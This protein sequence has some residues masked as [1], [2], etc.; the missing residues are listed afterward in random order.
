MLRDTLSVCKEVFTAIVPIALLTLCTLILIP[1][2]TPD[3][4]FRFISGTVMVI[5]GITLFLMGVKIG[6]LPMGETIGSAL[7]RIGTIP[8]IIL[9]TFS[10]GFFAAIAEPGVRVLATMILEISTSSI[11]KTAL[12]IAIATGIGFFVT[13]AILRILYAVPLPYL[14]TAGYGLALILALFSPPD[15]VPLAFDA[16]GVATGPI[17]APFI[18]S[19]GVGLTSVLGGR[20]SLS[21]G[22]GLIGLAAVGPVLGILIMGFFSS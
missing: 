2:T 9:I 3:A 15:F 21:D 10:F 17:T 14:L 7:P 6:V 19:L 13:T 4:Y 5:L 20:S 22:F 18:L 1:D 11:D 12:I 16:G 8:L